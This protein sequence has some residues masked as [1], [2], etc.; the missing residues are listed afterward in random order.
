M[1]LGLEIVVGSHVWA[2]RDEVL[3]DEASVGLVVRIEFGVR[4]LYGRL[5]C[6]LCVSYL[7]QV[8]YVLASLTKVALAARLQR[9]LAKLLPI[10][11]LNQ[12]VERLDLIRELSERLCL[13]LL[14]RVGLQRLFRWYV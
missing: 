7:V 11:V 14:I 13:I 4:L 3:F 12:L 8:D 10:N 6:I 2:V 9:P 1:V 5:N